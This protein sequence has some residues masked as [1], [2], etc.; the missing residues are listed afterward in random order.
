[1]ASYIDRV[2]RPWIEIVLFPISVPLGTK[3]QP[4]TVAAGSG[5]ACSDMHTPNP[6]SLAVASGTSA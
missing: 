4:A 6:E 3:V 5:F 1:M 2:E